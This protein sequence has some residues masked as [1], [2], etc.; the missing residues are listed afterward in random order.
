MKNLSRIK[1]IRSA[2]QKERR[3]NKTIGFVAT[4]GALHEGHLSLV[5]RS[6]LENKI[7][8]CSIFVNPIQFNNPEDLKNYPQTINEDLGLLE[9]AGCDYVFTPDVKE[10]YP[11]GSYGS[12]VKDFGPME[13]VLEGKFR[14]GHFKG[15][16]IVVKKLFDIISPDNAYFGNKDYQQLMIIR[17]LVSQLNL[18][19]NVIGCPIVR[20][21]DG[22]AMSSRN[23]QLSIGERKISSLIYKVLSEVKEKAGAASILE[24]KNLGIKKISSNPSFKLEYFEIVDKQTFLPPVSW[25]NRDNAIACIAVYLG[26]VRLI[27]NVELF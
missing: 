7:T 17:S 4:M 5:R 8:V 1:D 24:L 12:P 25:K 21:P 27:D 20:E 11:E 6:R 23:M 22:L 15:V 26:G 10:M 3:R 19:V 16:A 2:L 18:P 13:K 14:P 9:S